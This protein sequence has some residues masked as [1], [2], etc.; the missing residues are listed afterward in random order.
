MD[1]RREVAHNYIAP[2]QNTLKGAG[3]PNASKPEG[4][5]VDDIRLDRFAHFEGPIQGTRE[6]GMQETTATVLCAH[7]AA[8]VMSAGAFRVFRNTTRC[9]CHFFAKKN[10]I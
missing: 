9:G 4:R 5:V 10:I 7:R 2:S 1:V 3:R 6:E 8:S